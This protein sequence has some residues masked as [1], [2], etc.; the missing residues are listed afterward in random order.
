MVTGGAEA[1]ITGVATS[2]FAAMAGLPGIPR[3][4]DARRDGSAMGEGAGVL[5]E[6]EAAEKRGATILGE[7]AGYGVTA[8][9]YRAAARG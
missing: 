5:E 6:M 2:A 3:P 8:D 4:F 7:V 9:A 1:L